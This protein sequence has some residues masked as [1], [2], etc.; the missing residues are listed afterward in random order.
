VAVLDAGNVAPQKPGALFDI[1]LGEL[2]RVSEFSKSVAYDR[3]G[4][5]SF[6]QIE[7]NKAQER[8]RSEG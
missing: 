6:N 3:A 1:A 2:F 5:I 8:G 7:R 4:I